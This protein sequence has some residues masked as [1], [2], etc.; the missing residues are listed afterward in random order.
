MI[1][2]LIY[3]FSVVVTLVTSPV[4]ASAFF[5]EQGD[6]GCGSVSEIA[7]IKAGAAGNSVTAVPHVFNVE[8][9]G[10][11]PIW[12]KSNVVRITFGVRQ[13][14]TG[15]GKYNEASKYQWL[16]AVYTRLRAS[17]GAVLAANWVTIDQTDPGYLAQGVAYYFPQLGSRITTDVNKVYC[18]GLFTDNG[19]GRAGIGISGLMTGYGCTEDM[20]GQVTTPPIEKC[21]ATSTLNIDFGEVDRAGIT[22]T[23]A[24]EKSVKLSI[25]CSGVS[26]LPVHTFQAKLSGTGVT[27]A[28]GQLKT[29]NPALGV[30]LNIAGKDVNASS[31]VPFDLG[32]TSGGALNVTVKAA[33]AKDPGVITRDIET[34]SFSANATLIIEE[35]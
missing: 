17:S 3:I 29:S 18:L 7:C 5:A 20:G 13:S 4:S 2:S 25:N 21:V 19:S 31:S 6:A 14:T 26:V 35:K 32:S 27:W 30:K 33:L 1:K 24:Y 12:A 34:G 10:N 11:P 15:T 28:G 8:L 16:P 23:G 22:N 9:N